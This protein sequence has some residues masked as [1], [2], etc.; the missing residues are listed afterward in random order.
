MTVA[1]NLEMGAYAYRKDRDDRDP[2]HR[3]GAGSLSHPRGQ[4]L[5]P[6]RFT[7]RWP[8]TDVGAGARALHDP[9]ILLIDELSLGLAPVAVQE[10]LAVLERLRDEGLTIV[11]VEQ[12]VDVAL[13]IADRAVFMEKGEVRFEDWRKTSAVATTCSVP[14]SSAKE[15]AELGAVRQV[16]FDGIV[17]GLVV[18]LLAMGVVLVYRATRVLNFAVGNIGLIGATLLSVL[19][20]RYHTPFWVAAPL[21][22]LVGTMFAALVESR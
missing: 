18:G 3:T 10:L 4:I 16:G 5:G 7:F 13:S 6:C 9:E 20:V 12:S 22:L 11:V 15:V 1:Q 21:A 2:T 17:S 14:S 19:V 8:T